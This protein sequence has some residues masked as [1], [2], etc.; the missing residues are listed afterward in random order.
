MQLSSNRL[1][2]L[3]HRVREG[4][5]ARTSI[6]GQGEV[7]QILLLHSLLPP[8]VRVGQVCFPS[9]AHTNLRS[10]R[11]GFDNTGVSHLHGGRWSADTGQQQ[12]GLIQVTGLQTRVGQEGWQQPDDWK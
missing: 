2:Y 12:E 3:A 4:P 7:I 10:S 6:G 5:A 8:S 9:A 1:V 11:K